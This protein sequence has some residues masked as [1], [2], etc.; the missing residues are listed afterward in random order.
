MP[1]RRRV[2]TLRI[3]IGNH[4]TLTGSARLNDIMDEL[5]QLTSSAGFPRRSWLLAVLHTTRTLDTT[6][7]EVVRFKGWLNPRQQPSLGAYLVALRNNAILSPTER[8]HY[9]AVVV[10]KRN[11]YMHQAGAIPTRIDADTL[12][13]EMQTCVVDVLRRVL[14]MLCG[15]STRPS[16]RR[17]LSFVVMGNA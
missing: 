10:S 4:Y 1:Y 8:N 6:L 9:Q 17:T 14:S 3:L 15:P 16:Y 11:I 13:A 12:L 5:N 2:A 7:S